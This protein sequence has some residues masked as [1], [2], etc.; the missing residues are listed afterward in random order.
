[1]PIR[2]HASDCGVTRAGAIDGW[3]AIRRNE[4][5]RLADDPVELHQHGLG[6]DVGFTKGLSYQS[7][8]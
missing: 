2:G 3:D 6:A 8:A 5:H 4:R 7:S 1:M